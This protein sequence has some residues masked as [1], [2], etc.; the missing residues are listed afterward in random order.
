[1]LDAEFWLHLGDLATERGQLVTAAAHYLRAWEADTPQKAA[2]ASRTDA[3]TGS[4]VRLGRP[5][6]PA[7]PTLVQSSDVPVR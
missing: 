6:Q 3:L 2:A 7:C 5:D 1:M 4:G